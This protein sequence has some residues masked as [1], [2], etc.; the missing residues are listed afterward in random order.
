MLQT[1]EPQA[2]KAIKAIKATE[3]IEATTGP[4]SVPLPRGLKSPTVVSM[5]LAGWMLVACLFLPLCRSCGGSVLRPVEVIS[6]SLSAPGHIS[7][8]FDGVTLLA[9]Y[10]NGALAASVLAISA[11]RRNPAVLRRAFA[12]Q[13]AIS[14]GLAVVFA[15]LVLADESSSP[16]RTLVGG[17]AFI[18]PLVMA[19]WWVQS[20]WRRGDREAAWARLQHLW[21]FGAL[22][23]MHLMCI[24]ATEVLIGYWLTLA[25]LLAMVLAVELA[26]H[27]MR[28]DLWDASRPPARIQFTLRSLFLWMTI[29]PLV[30]GYYRAIELLA[31]WLFPS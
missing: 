11:Y 3:A 9:V 20:A 16:K 23:Y 31:D 10:C 25:S 21:T 27:R 14:L 15:C 24:F 1:P 6:T 26:R 5:Q 22:V 8:V 30:T 7:S 4:T 18:P 17:L 13:Y 29:L 2:G 28:H 19:A 12:T